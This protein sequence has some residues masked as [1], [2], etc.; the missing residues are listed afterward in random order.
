[1]WM[2]L[3]R[4]LRTWVVLAVVLP[5]VRTVVH[6]AAIR[7]QTRSPDA[8]PARLLARTDSALT[9]VFGPATRGQKT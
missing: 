2:F 3:S 8:K 6:K 1:M 7:E 9:K 5:V 4:R